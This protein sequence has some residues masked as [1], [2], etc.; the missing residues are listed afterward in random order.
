[1]GLAGGEGERLTPTGAESP[2]RSQMGGQNV[3]TIMLVALAVA[4]VTEELNHKM[5]GE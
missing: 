1:M 2:I 5:R 3:T 4:V